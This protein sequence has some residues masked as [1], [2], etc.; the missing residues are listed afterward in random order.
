MRGVGWGGFAYSK[1]KRREDGWIRSYL[2]PTIKETE[3]F[4]PSLNLTEFSR[5]CLN[6]S[7]LICYNYADMICHKP[8]GKMRNIIESTMKR[9]RKGHAI[10]FSFVFSVQIP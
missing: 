3:H 1:A 7:S 5:K 8:K 9:P 2:D 6:M 10:V 4:Y